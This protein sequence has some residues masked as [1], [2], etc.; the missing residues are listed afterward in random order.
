MKAR[1]ICTIIAMLALFAAC[2]Q[3]QRA[4]PAAPAA[5]T[6][7]PAPPATTAAPASAQE[8]VGMWTTT[9]TKEDLLRV[10]PDFKPEYLCDNAG[11]FVWRFKADGTFTIDQNALE[12]CKQPA[13]AHIESS[14]SSEG[15]LV[16]FAKGT[17]D[18]EV[19][20][21]S[22]ASDVLTFK[23]RSGDCIPCKATNTANPWKRLNN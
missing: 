10:V 7:A 1:H 2:G 3:A 21:W 12:G 14:W 17:A 8:L 18:Q 13:S 19:Y 9:V 6:A 23:H 20:E 5:N 4:T 15:N 16:T 22:I 11:T